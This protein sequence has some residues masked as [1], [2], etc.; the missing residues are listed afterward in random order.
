MH[1]DIRY[2]ARSSNSVD[3]ES[4]LNDVLLS[5]CMNDI[6]IK[7]LQRAG[8]IAKEVIANARAYIKKGMPLIEI[9]EYIEKEIEKLGGKPAF[10]VNLS[11][12]E[13]A[14][15]ATPAYGDTQT[16]H[17]LLKVDL[18]VHIEGHI[19]DTAF[20]L[21]LEGSEE[22]RQLIAAAESAVQ[23]AV[24]L[25]QEKQNPKIREIGKKIATVIEERG[26]QPITNLS[27]HAITRYEVHAGL[28]IPNYDNAQEKVID[29]GVYAI[30]P[31]AT[32]ATGGGAVR[33]GKPSTIYVLQKDGKVRDA[34][35]RQV[36]QYIEEEY[37]TL[38]FCSRWLYKKFGSRALIAL[39][40]IEEAGLV[41]HYPQLIEISGNKVAQAE[42]TIIIT[43]KEVI[44]TTA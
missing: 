33:D 29:K 6:E 27:G 10:P 11:I 15:H 37:K 16:A 26:A 4:Y 21:D 23:E 20:S 28:T 18:G 40:R 3:A 31:F 1:T 25:V 41:H 2:L 34:F 39:K 22:N 5:A 43:D 13:I 19:A 35:A 36:L 42:H 7:H 38:P 32:V 30:E 24:R 9:A 17:G 8:T 44:V 12:N 14:A